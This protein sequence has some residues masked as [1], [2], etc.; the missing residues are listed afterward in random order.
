M[1][2]VLLNLKRG[3]YGEWDSY[4]QTLDSLGHS[5]MIRGQ[6]PWV[7]MPAPLEGRC[8]H[9]TS[10]ILIRSTLVH[11]LAWVDPLEPIQ[12]NCV[13]F[14]SKRTLFALFS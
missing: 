2:V 14:G 13:D 6:I 11:T 1:P 10:S 9:A 5:H 8:D 3:I 4:D 12:T 7:V